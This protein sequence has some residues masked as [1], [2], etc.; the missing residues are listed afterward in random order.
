MGVGF[1]WKYWFRCGIKNRG[2]GL[3]H[4]PGNEEVILA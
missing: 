3:P 2:T 1:K 4:M